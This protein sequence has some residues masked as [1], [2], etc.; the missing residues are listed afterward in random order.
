MTVLTGFH[1]RS[2]RWSL[3]NRRYFSLFCRLVKA[4]AKRTKGATRA[5]QGST[6]KIIKSYFST[7]FLIACVA[8]STPASCFALPN[9]RKTAPLL[10]VTNQATALLTFHADRLCRQSPLHYRLQSYSHR[11]LRRTS[12]SQLLPWIACT[13]APCCPEIIE[14]QTISWPLLRAGSDAAPLMCRT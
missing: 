9:A 3:Q 14:K 8:R 7:P 11:P 5:R 6:E 13:E 4:S 10:Q 1:C 2:K 12:L